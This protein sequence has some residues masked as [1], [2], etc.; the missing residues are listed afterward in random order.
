MSLDIQAHSDPADSDQSE[1]TSSKPALQCIYFVLRC[2]RYHVF[3]QILATSTPP[4]RAV[5]G[6]VR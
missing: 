2:E 6:V 5:Q 1:V 3:R 4:T